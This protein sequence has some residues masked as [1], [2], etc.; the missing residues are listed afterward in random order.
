[1]SRGPGIVQRRLVAA[2]QAEPAR[3][4]TV[5][6]LTAIAFPA[7]EVGRAGLAS[8]RRALIGLAVHR[9]CAGRSGRSG[10]RYFVSC[11]E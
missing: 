7:A 4:F 2:L 10:W 5:E 1:M 6:E 9:Q 3:R 11:A 8:V